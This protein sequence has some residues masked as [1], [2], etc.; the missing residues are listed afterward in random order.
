MFLPHNVTDEDRW[1]QVINEA[2]DV[3]GKV[4]ILVNNAGFGRLQTVDETRSDQWDRV[5]DVN[6]KGVFF[7]CKYIVTAMQKAG[8]GSIVNIS[9]MYGLVGAPAAAA[10]QAAKG[11]G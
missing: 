1:Q 2:V 5:M 6:A 9:S 4:D 7:G 3:Y 11:A 8:G 10:H